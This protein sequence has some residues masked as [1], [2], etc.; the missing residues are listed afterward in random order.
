VAKENFQAVKRETKLKHGDETLKRMLLAAELASAPANPTADA[1]RLAAYADGLV[2]AAKPG[3]DVL[4]PHLDSG[5]RWPDANNPRPDDPLWDGGVRAGVTWDGT[6]YRDV[7]RYSAG[8]QLF[9]SA[10]FKPGS[11]AGIKQGFWFNFGSGWSHLAN[12]DP[13]QLLAGASQRIFFDSGTGQ[14]R[15][16]IEATMFVT[17]AVVNVWTGTKAG[18]SDPAGIYQR[19]SG[20]DPLSAL[21][22]EAA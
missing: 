20:C 12:D 1:Y 6:F 10:Y 11:A 8:G 7:T 16:V 15:L 4:L 2:G 5:L 14:W 3:C 19:A 13:A 21:T 9:W 18:G 17:N 22:V